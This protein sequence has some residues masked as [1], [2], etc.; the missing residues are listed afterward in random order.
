MDELNIC[1]G[2]EVVFQAEGGGLRQGVL[3]QDREFVDAVRQGREPACSAADALKS[4][5]VLQAV[6]DQMVELD[7]EER[8]R[9][10]WGL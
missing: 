10:V 9:R 4:L 2:G 8:Y 5:A 3:V 6:Y 7:G 1:L